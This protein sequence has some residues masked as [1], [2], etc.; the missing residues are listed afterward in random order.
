MKGV[1]R[2]GRITGATR[3]RLLRNPVRRR[4]SQAS[5]AFGGISPA[6]PGA[7]MPGFHHP[8]LA[9]GMAYYSCSQPVREQIVTSLQKGLFT[10]ETAEYAEQY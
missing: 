5:S 1:S 8:R 3:R 7:P 10:A 4:G 2:S 6:L 9:A